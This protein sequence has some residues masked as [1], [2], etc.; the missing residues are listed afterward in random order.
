M[1]HI[2][3]QMQSAGFAGRLPVTAA[4]QVRSGLSAVDEK[5]KL[6]AVS[7]KV[8]LLHRQSWSALADRYPS[9]KL[10]RDCRPG[11]YDMAPLDDPQSR[12]ITK[13]QVGALVESRLPWPRQPAHSSSS[14]LRNKGTLRSRPAICSR[15]STSRKSGSL[16]CEP[17]VNGAHAIEPG[18]LDHHGDGFMAL[19]KQRLL[20]EVVAG[21]MAQFQPRWTGGSIIV[22]ER[23]T[24]DTGADQVETLRRIA[25][26]EYPGAGPHFAEIQP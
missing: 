4:F 16:Q 3:R 19:S 12:P 1:F 7:P 20:P 22:A 5:K 13:W 8:H 11:H 18:V 21:L 26:A 15:S 25:G 14:R 24:D 2:Q 23:L 9:G 10:S 6:P 17:Q